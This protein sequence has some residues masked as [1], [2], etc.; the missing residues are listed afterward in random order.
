MITSALVTHSGLRGC[1]P[2]SRTFNPRSGPVTPSGRAGIWRV[3]RGIQG[4]SVA[5]AM[6]NQGPGPKR[7][8]CPVTRGD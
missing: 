4:D 3:E 1:E 7:P 5:E 6:G 8:I 2:V